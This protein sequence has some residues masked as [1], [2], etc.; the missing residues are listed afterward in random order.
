M[1]SSTVSVRSVIE[2]TIALSSKAPIGSCMVW[3]IVNVIR[4]GACRSVISPDMTEVKPVTDLM[5]R[6][7][8]Q[9]IIRIIIWLKLV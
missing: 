7:S 4:S 3:C 2:M 5:V 8:P 1:C 6:S 9:V